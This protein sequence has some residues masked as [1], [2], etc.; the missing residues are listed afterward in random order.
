[1]KPAED[2]IQ[3]DDQRRRFFVCRSMCELEQATVDFCDAPGQYNS[4]QIQEYI[5][6]R[7]ETVRYYNVTF[8]IGDELEEHITTE[9]I[10]NISA[11]YNNLHCLHWGNVNPTSHPLLTEAETNCR[12]LARHYKK[13]GYHGE[14]GIDFGLRRDAAFFLETNARINNGTRLFYELQEL[15]IEPKSA[16]YLLLRNQPLALI[17]DA[18]SEFADRGQIALRGRT[19]DRT[20]ILAEDPKPIHAIH[21][22]ISELAFA[23]DPLPF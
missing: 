16:Y 10:I 17:T 15:G 13:M 4:F 8:K 9:Q 7:N 22:E 12:R 5:D 14:I 3:L 6:F 21:K 18:V 19:D 11:I 1:M 23:P 20:L 2:R